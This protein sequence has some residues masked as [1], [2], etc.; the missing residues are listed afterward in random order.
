MGLEPTTPVLQTGASP[1]RLLA[2][3]AS[4]ATNAYVAELLSLIKRFKL[5][6]HLYESAMGCGCL[7]FDK[8]SPSFLG[9]SYENFDF[10][11]WVHD[12]LFV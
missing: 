5:R 1:F 8:N 11:E 10:P 3:I 4:G 6:Y 7:H 12:L 2:R 9:G